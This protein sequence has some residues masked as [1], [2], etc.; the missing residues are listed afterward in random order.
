[1][2]PNRALASRLSCRLTRRSCAPRRTRWVFFTN[3]AQ[4]A[5]LRR[6]AQQPLMCTARLQRSPVVSSAPLLCSFGTVSIVRK[7]SST[8]LE[9]T[10]THNTRAPRS[11]LQDMYAAMLSSVQDAQLSDTAAA[12]G[13]PSARGGAGAQDVHLAFPVRLPCL[14]H[15]QGGVLPSCIGLHCDPAHS[16]PG[17]CYAAKS[18]VF[19]AA[20]RLFAYAQNS[21]FLATGRKRDAGGS[22]DAS[23]SRCA[24]SSTGSG[25]HAQR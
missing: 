17:I 16:N 1:M 12:S 3:G 2:L 21:R 4:R 18:E 10:H 7:P 24:I 14:F 22:R 13:S 19:F 23:S 25:G 11:R 5:A 20:L 8:R 15:G 9:G 6:A